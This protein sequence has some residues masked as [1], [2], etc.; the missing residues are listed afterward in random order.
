[1]RKTTAD[2]SLRAHRPSDDGFIYPL[3]DRIFAAYSIHPTGSMASMLAEDGAMAFVAERGAAPFAAAQPVGFFVLGFARLLAELWPLAAPR[4]RPAQRHRR[5]ARSARAGRGPLPPR[6]RRGRRPRRGRGLPLPD[7]RRDQRPRAPPLHRR[8]L[9]GGPH[10]GAL[11][12]ARPARH[13]HD[14]SALDG[15]PA[16][17]TPGL[18]AD[19]VSRGRRSRPR[20]SAAPRCR[21]GSTG[22]PRRTPRTG[23]PCTRARGSSPDTSPARRA[24]R[25]RRCCRSRRS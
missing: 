23:T 17:Q 21:A 6:A 5:A 1:M 9:P 12:R 7:D 19:R 4:G 3:S 15:G 18:R 2:L 24:G 16:P 13:R 14:Q 20:R 8:R 10:A 11:L 22:C 25:C